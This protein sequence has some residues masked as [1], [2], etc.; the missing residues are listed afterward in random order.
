MLSSLTVGFSTVCGDPF[1]LLL[2][3]G[4]VTAGIAFGSIPGISTTMAIALFLAIS[5]K[6]STIQEMSLLVAIYIGG[7]SGG[8]I[9]AILLRMPGTPSSVATCFDGY[10]MAKRGS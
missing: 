7:I 1:T 6:L 3:F 9:S 2:I 8:L 5:F 10:P 4:G